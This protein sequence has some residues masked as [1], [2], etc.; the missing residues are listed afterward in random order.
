VAGLQ[1]DRR[2]GRTD[3]SI[4]YGPLAANGKSTIG[5]QCREAIGDYG[6]TIN[7]ETFLDEGRRSAATRRRPTWCDCPAC[8]C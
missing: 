8:A 3:L 5:N 2:H 7:V 4:W 1:P 6:D